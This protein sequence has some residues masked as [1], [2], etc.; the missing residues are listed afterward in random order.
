MKLIGYVRVSTETQVDGFGLDVQEQALRDWAKSNGHRLVKIFREEGVSGAKELEDR[1]ALADALDALDGNEAKGIVFPK[2]DRLAR[3]L[4]VQETLIA[5]I[6]KGGS[7]IFSAVPGEA[8]FLKDDPDDP[9]RKLI[10][11][12]LGA[13]SEYERAVI[14]LRMRK[15][16]A[17]KGRRGGYAYGAPAY[18]QRTTP[19]K[20][21]APEPTEQ[22][23]LT[24]MVSMH[25]DGASLREICDALHSAGHKPK[26]G[27]RWHPTTVSR[28]LARAR[29]AA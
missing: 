18:G 17:A 20:E 14:A 15:G 1:A 8:E 26:R 12:V 6:R 28:C 11:Q 13:V 3:D 9:S 19:E 21:L 29:Q 23:A 2:L 25:A 7:E 24:F 22:A 10:R 16:R 5:E 27:D 4:I